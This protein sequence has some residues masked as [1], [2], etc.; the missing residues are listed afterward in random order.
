MY[1]MAGSSSRPGVA[2]GI[3]DKGLSCSSAETVELTSGDNGCVVISRI[4]K[5]TR[6]SPRACNRIVDLH[7]GSGV[8][9]FVVTAKDI[10]HAVQRSR[11]EFLTVH[12]P[13]V[14]LIPNY[15]CLAP[16]RCSRTWAKGAGPRRD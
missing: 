16:S 6:E 8:T 7:C 5:G 15:N 11:G 13:E 2:T 1:I 12:R 3:I 9:I 4:R 14:R 10:Q